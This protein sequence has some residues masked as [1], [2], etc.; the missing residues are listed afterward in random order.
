LN[1][2]K[3]SVY[4]NIVSK[5]KYIKEIKIM[6]RSKN[7]DTHIANIKKEISDTEKKLVTLHEE[8]ET[9]VKEKEQQDVDVLYKYVRE[10]NISFSDVIKTLNSDINKDDSSKTSGKSS[11]TAASRKTSKTKELNNQPEKKRPGR[12]KKNA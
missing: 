12:P 1:I 3:L 2:I 4:N 8:L 10:N 9:M 11:K 6:A 5:K 7:Y